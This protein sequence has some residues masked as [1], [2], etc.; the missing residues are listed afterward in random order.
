MLLTEDFNFIMQDFVVDYSFLQSHSKHLFLRTELMY[1]PQ[2][3]SP[4]FFVC[5]SFKVLIICQGL[6]FCDGKPLATSPSLILLNYSSTL[7]VESTYQ[8][9][10]GHIHPSSWTAHDGTH[11]YN[12]DV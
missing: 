9:H 5:Y 12:R 8:I 11:F 4:F 2:W 1:T 10:L 6:L 7:V 3:V